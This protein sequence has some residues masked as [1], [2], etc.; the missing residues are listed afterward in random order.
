MATL[1]V[2][3]LQNTAATVTN[4]SLLA[5]GSTTIVLNATGTNR[6]GGLR[7]NAGNLEVYTSGGIWVAAGGGSG[8]VTGVTATL[9]MVSTGGT[10]PVISIGLG[11][12]TVVNGSNIAV[13]IPVAS[14][15]PAIGTGATQGLN[16]SMYWDDT[17]GQ[18]FIRYINGGTPVWVA[19]APPAGGSSVI[20]AGT[21]MVFAQ[22]AAP[23]GW[24]QDT[25]A[26]LNDSALRLV[27]TAGGGTGGTVAFTT[28]FASGLSSAGHILTVAEMPNHNHSWGGVDS[29]LSAAGGAG[30]VLTVNPAVT[31]FTGGDGAH[32]H[33]LP[34]IAVKYVDL[35]IAVKN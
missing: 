28:A 5:D 29:G 1:Q 8:T 4:V 19:A 7:Y 24:T 31:G 15:P 22:A 16:G 12:G 6:T 18:L 23:T 14:T 25:T 30:A 32:S 33:S 21:R 13:S 11:L 20:P 27:N 9:P 3:N 10:A 26:A 35:I 34:S 17:L 2:T